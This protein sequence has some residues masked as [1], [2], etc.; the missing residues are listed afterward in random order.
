MAAN[1][2][3]RVALP[4]PDEVL[5]ALRTLGVLIGGI[6]RLTVPVMTAKDLATAP[7]KRLNGE[8]EH[9]EEGGTARIALTVGGAY[10]TWLN[11]CPNPLL[12]ETARKVIGGLAY[13]LRVETIGDRIRR[14]RARA[15]VTRSSMRSR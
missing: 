11:L 10:K 13:K 14:T 8:I 4:N 5:D 2:Y 3:T 12:V 1:R 7:A 15:I 9:L 6:V